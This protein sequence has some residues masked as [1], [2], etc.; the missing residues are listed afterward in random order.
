MLIADA[1]AG[2]AFT[3]ARYTRKQIVVWGESLGS[4]VAVALAADKP[5]GRVILEAPFTSAAAVAAGRYWYLPVRLL[6]KD[7]FRSDERIGKV[8][9]PVLIHAEGDP[10]GLA[11]AGAADSVRSLGVWEPITRKRRETLLCRLISPC[12]SQS[13]RR[14]VRQDLPEGFHATVGQDGCGSRVAAARRCI[15]C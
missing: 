12:F 14:I 6:M 4:G 10:R 9:A 2:Y 1:E 13:F 15:F 5:V 8:T 11:I 3:E 7:Q